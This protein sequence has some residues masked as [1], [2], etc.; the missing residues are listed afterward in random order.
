[1]TTVYKRG[2]KGSWIISYFDHTGTRR[3]KSSGTTDRR[4]AQRIAAKIGAE[5]ALRSAGVID[6]AEDG[7]AAAER[8]EA[9]QHAADFQKFLEAK[10]NTTRHVNT[11]HSDVVRLFGAGGVSRLSDLKPSAVMAGLDFL[12]KGLDLEEDKR[13]TRSLRTLNRVL[14]AVKGFSRWLV[15]DGRM[16]V[17]ALAHLVPFNASTDQRH[18]RRILTT[19]EFRTLLSTAENGPVRYDL[20]GRDRWALYLIAAHT[21]FR[22]SELASLTPRS[23]DL[24]AE[25]PTITV[26]AG[27]SKHRREDRQPIRADLAAALNPWLETKAVGEPVFDTVRLPDKTA[28][29]L[30][31]DLGVAGIKY[32]DDA[33]RYADFHSL[34]H[35]FVSAMT[36]A[37]NVSPKMTMELARHSDPKLTLATYSHLR[38]EDTESA[39]ANL[40]GVVPEP[41]DEE[42]VQSRTGTDDEPVET[43][44]G[45]Q[46]IRQQL[47]HDLVQ[48]RTE[49]CTSDAVEDDASDDFTD[50]RNDL[51]DAD[52]CQAVH[53][54]AGE[55]GWWARQDSNLRPMDY[56]SKAGCRKQGRGRDLES[57]L[58]APQQIRQQSKASRQI[59]NEGSRADSRDSRTWNQQPHP[60]RSA[61]GTIHTASSTVTNSADPGRDPTDLTE[62][63]R[64]VPAA[65]RPLIV[66]HVQ[67]LLKLSPARR[68]AIITL[69]APEVRP[70]N[71]AAS[72]SSC[73]GEPRRTELHTDA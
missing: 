51:E 60:R 40:P 32:K 72:D 37:K 69:A 42:A 22:A 62:I 67:T 1:M 63:L 53:A 3:Q 56:E 16:K 17:D 8:L 64:S 50:K 18:P 46:Q 65:E 7:F 11:T 33:D 10:G 39:L 73:R 19:K 35:L 36:N 59:L 30:R 9:K 28:R 52:L 34:R 6:A 57:R 68:A 45:C 38:I 25:Q 2:G 5:V 29:M 15:R 48:S 13:K 12:R 24:K 41:T 54:G 58:T 55:E 49:S 61:G 31:Q 27:Y 20:S 23:F 43:E 4:A 47:Q 14:T 21:G 66:E 44:K 26:L 70:S 71:Q